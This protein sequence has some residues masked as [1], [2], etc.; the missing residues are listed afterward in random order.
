L[1]NLEEDSAIGDFG[2]WMKGFWSCGVA[3]SR[4]SVWGGLGEGFF[5]GEPER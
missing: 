5:T 2:S 3:L 4:G 1:G